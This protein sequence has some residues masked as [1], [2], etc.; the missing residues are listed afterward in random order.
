[1]QISFRHS[2]YKATLSQPS[3]DENLIHDFVQPDNPLPS[4][5]PISKCVTSKAIIRPAPA[6]D[7]SDFYDDDYRDD[8]E[9][10]I[11]EEDDDELAEFDGD[12][13]EL[14][15]FD[16][17]DNEPTVFDDEDPACSTIPNPESS[18][19]DPVITIQGEPPADDKNKATTSTFYR[20]NSYEGSNINY[21][22]YSYWNK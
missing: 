16:E 6:A 9:L 15:V 13:E 4:N 18:T 10:T 19:P 17:E 22:K 8:E 3:D 1:M 7:D 21:Q 20:N 2:N 5:H 11:F 12:D 14:I